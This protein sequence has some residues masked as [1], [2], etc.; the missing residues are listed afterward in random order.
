MGSEAFIYEAAFR[1]VTWRL[2]TH[3]V[4]KTTA[5]NRSE[6][7]PITLLRHNRE[8]AVVPSTR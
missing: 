8:V 5:F 1:V 3:E 4:F 6:R 7:L 2:A